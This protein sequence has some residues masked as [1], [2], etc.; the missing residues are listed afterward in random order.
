MSMETMGVPNAPIKKEQNVIDEFTLTEISAEEAR[1]VLSRT[2]IHG[3][4]FNGKELTTNILK[5]EGLSPS[6]K[7]VLENGVT[8][9]FSDLY[10]TE[11]NG[12]VAVVAYVKNNGNYFARTYYLSNSQGV[13]RYLPSYLKKEDGGI[14][15]YNKGHGEESVTIPVVFQKALADIRDKK[16]PKNVS[17]AEF[18]FAGTARDA[19]N[20]DS[21][22][23]TY[24]REVD[25]MPQIFPTKK[26]YGR[27]KTNPENLK[28][29]AG[30]SPDFSKVVASWTT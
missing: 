10:D 8:C 28:L 29:E 3:D 25:S 19:V 22:K 7:V 24:S 26:F 6:S 2:E 13:W 30:Q 5:I 18:I 23:G 4:T 27:S 15:W 11:H 12:R 1:D 9:F 21:E 14:F 16:T 20:R 17:D